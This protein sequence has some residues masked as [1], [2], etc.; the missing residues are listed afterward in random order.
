MSLQTE[1]VTVCGDTHGQ[2]YDLLHIF[3][4]NGLPCEENPYG[5]EGGGGRN[6]GGGTENPYVGY[7]GGVDKYGGGV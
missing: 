4:L 1:M 5:R 3:E 6:M 7:G 2:F